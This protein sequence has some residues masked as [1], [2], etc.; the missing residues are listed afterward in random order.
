MNIK[1]SFLS[2]LLVFCLLTACLAGCQEG[3][4]D[5]SDD[6]VSTEFVDYVANTTLNMQSGT[7]KQEVTV[8][9]YIDGDTTHFF[10]PES[11]DPDGVL[12]ARYM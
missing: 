10:V 5:N 9:S 6:S 3:G 2:I 11:I 12:K 8:K 4:T 7:K 1:K